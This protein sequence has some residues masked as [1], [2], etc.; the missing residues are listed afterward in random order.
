MS[1]ATY[2]VTMAELKEPAH[3]GLWANYGSPVQMPTGR[4]SHPSALDPV[5]ANAA[6]GA[7]APTPHSAGQEQMPEA[8][9]ML[10]IR[11][12]RRMCTADPMEHPQDHR[13]RH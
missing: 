9:R 13:I 1:T 2:T 12:T 11:K 3:N 8:I 6:A 5:L 10:A 7:Q 4:F